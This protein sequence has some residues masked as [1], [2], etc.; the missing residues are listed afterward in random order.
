MATGMVAG[1]GRVAS[2][3]PMTAR[4]KRYLQRFELYLFLRE[5]LAALA[6]TKKQFYGGVVSLSFNGPARGNV[7]VSYAN[8]GLIMLRRGLPVPT[9]H[10]Q[11]WK[12]IAMA[13]S[14]VDL[15]YNVDV[16]HTQ[17]QQFIPWKR[18]DVIVDTRFNLQRLH[19]YLDR[20]CIKILHC[21]TA[22]IVFHNAAEMGRILSLQERKGV[23]I[24]PSRFERPNLGAEYA[25][26]ITTCGN[27]F[28]MRTY[29]YAKKPV[30]N[31][32]ITVEAKWSWPK[33]KDFDQCR[34]QFLWFASRGMVHKGLDLVLDAFTGLPE[35]QLTIVGPVEDE[36]EFVQLYRNELYHLP[37]IKLIGWMHKEN[38]DFK[39][40]LDR[41]VAHV[42]TSCSESGAACVLETMGA[43]VIPIVNY[44]SSVDV[45]DFGIL[46]K[47]ASIEDIRD[48]VRT[49]ANMPAVELKR[50]AMRAWEKVRSKYTRENFADSYKALMKTILVKHGKLPESS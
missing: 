47:S 39:R 8:Q 16:I 37:N 23:T 7:L 48:G 32:P 12:T 17:N 42:F 27:E 35:Y 49:I 6:Y 4:L 46:L 36:P 28:T 22:H 19:P 50:R 18:Y 5:A 43:G 26:Y 10:E 1:A 41:S 11:Y 45:D 34:K 2:I 21:D 20:D 31:L 30:Y 29:R 44:E 15:G 9:S 33:E 38:N 24:P 40:L 13:Q 14:F 25:D 3:V